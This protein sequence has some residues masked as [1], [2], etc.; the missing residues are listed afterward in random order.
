MSNLHNYSNYL[1]IMLSVMNG[2]LYNLNFK[3]LSVINV[4]V[5]YNVINACT[6]TMVKVCHQS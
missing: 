6:Y 3:D 2:S 5:N 1:Q 4:N